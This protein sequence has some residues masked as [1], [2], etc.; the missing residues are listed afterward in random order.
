V[1]DA[2]KSEKKNIKNII[3]GS[4]EYNVKAG[5]MLCSLL[6][7]IFKRCTS[8]RLFGQAFD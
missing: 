7:F 6:P 5:W 3:P 8:F 2:S 1:D 4:L